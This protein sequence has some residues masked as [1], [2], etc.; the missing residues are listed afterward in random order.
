MCVWS[1][2][3][4]VFEFVERFQSNKLE[5]KP[6]WLDLSKVSLQRW[7]TQQT[8]QRHRNIAFEMGRRETLSNQKKVS[9][10]RFSKHIKDGLM[11]VL[12]FS[13]PDQATCYFQLSIKADLQKDSCFMSI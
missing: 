9:E 11:Y 1:K 5:L 12:I 8:T 2:I 6:T 7:I 10:K 13:E 4:Q 3:L